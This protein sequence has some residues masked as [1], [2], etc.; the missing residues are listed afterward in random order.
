MIKLAVGIFLVVSKD[1]V[2]A[3]DWDID[4]GNLTYSKQ[5]TKFR[6]RMYERTTDPAAAETIYC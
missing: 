2:L 5:V 3:R 1:E 6:R 4:H